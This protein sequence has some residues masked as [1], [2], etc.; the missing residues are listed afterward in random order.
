MN[1]YKE[2]VWAYLHN[3]LPPET[4]AAFE[5]AVIDDPGLREILEECRKTHMELELL[6][7]HQMEERL[8]AEWE[9]E[10]PKYREKRKSQL[11][12][13]LRFSLPLLAAAATVLLLFALPLSQG[14]VQWQRTVY[15][16]PPQLRGQA[17]S[18]PHYSRAE[19]KQVDM[20]LRNTIESSLAKLSNPPSR[21]KLKIQLQELANG[22]LVVEISGYP[23]GSP[24][25]TR[26]WSETFEGLD[27]VAAEAPFLGRRIAEDLAERNNP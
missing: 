15:G 14:P 2:Q 10:H 25:Q 17:G 21:W 4:R 11:N 24:E 13:I 9:S 26:N 12:R 8:L 18:Q 22:F 19:L 20:A 3:E 27:H 23:R 6:A 7:D 5:Q 16:P 1:D